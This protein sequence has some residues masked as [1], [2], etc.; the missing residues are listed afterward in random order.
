M[1]P[2]SHNRQTF[3]NKV[4]KKLFPNLML[5]RKVEPLPLT[6][7]WRRVFILPTKPGMFFAFVTFLML[8]AS[9]NFNNNMGLM[10]TFLLVGLAQ[11]AMYRVFFNV[12]SL[13]IDHVKVKPV[14]LGKESCFMIH[15][16]ANESKYDICVKNKLKPNKNNDSCLAE[17][18][19]DEIHPIELKLATHKR[20]W[21]TLGKIKIL[22]SY[23]FGLFFAWIWTNIDSRCLVYPLPE[24][25]PPAFPNHTQDEGNS[26]VIKQG[27]D[28]HGLKPFQAGD[29]MRLIAWKRTAQSGE[30][31]S[32]EFQQT[33]GE[34]LLFDYSQISLSDPEAKLSRLTAW[35]IIAYQQ[36]LDYCLKLPHFDSG[37][38]YSSQ[39]HLSCLKELALFRLDR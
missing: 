21:L 13:I 19:A 9:L 5:H 4:A 31:I 34:K 20:G 35:I 12:R 11:V 37:F 24:P 36:Q 6:I 30:L 33:I 2:E 39:H 3:S 38:G 28:F 27:E 18:P 17:I 32:R 26:M 29:S 15:L 8:V 16:T 10:L 1:K 7:N 14:F 25:H 22:S 23:P